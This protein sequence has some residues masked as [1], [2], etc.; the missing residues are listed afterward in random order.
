MVGFTA[1]IADRGTTRTGIARRFD[2]RGLDR[3]RLGLGR[4]GH[5]SLW[6]LGD[7]L[8]CR[9]R[10][11]VVIVAQAAGID[12]VD[13]VAIDIGIAVEGGR[14]VTVDELA[15][16]GTIVTGPQVDQPIGIGRF[17]GEV[18]KGG[19]S[20]DSSG[21]NLDIVKMSGRISWI[22]DFS[23]YTSIPK[24]AGNNAVYPGQTK[25]PHDNLISIQF[26][27]QNQNRVS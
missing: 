15:E 17:A 26:D 9:A 10:Q 2:N 27:Y 8:E 20:A 13:G 7:G 24:G 11:E 5:R 22:C 12:T 19:V 23:L 21:I 18:I 25:Y 3:G 1:R 16:G 4:F 14:R 6:R